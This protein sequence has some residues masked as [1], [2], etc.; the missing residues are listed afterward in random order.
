[1]E[2]LKSR[3][4]IGGMNIILVFLHL[5]RLLYDCSGPTLTVGPPAEH[6]M[7]TLVDNVE[8][9]RECTVQ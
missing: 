2:R 3:L 9:S 1:M 8:Y 5:T 6:V 7:A 4:E